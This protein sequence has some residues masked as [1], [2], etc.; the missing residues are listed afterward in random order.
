MAYYPQNPNGQAANANS[1]PVTLSSEQQGLFMNM[2]LRLIN[3]ANSTALDA[4]S[5]RLR[6]F[7]DPLGGAQTLGTVSSVSTVTTVTTVTLCNLGLPSLIVDVASAAIIS[8]A[9]TSAFAPTF[10]CSYEVCIVVTAVSGTTPTYDVNIEESDDGGTN[11]FVVYS[12]PRQTST[13]DRRSPKL[14]LRGNRVRYAQVITGSSPSFTRVI[15]RLQ[16]SDSP[17]SSI[18]QRIDRT[19][20]LVTLNSTTLSLNTQNGTTAQLSINIGAATT[21][22]I[23]Q[24]EGTD[25]NGTTWYSVGTTL[26]AVANSTVQVSVPDI[27][28]Q[29]LRARVQTA[30][31]V[32]TA[33]YVLIKA[34]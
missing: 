19:I 6:V 27:N 33:G 21:A 30:G 3:N 34:F 8:S 10:G 11:W 24:L 29:F 16:S 28:S 7:L 20:D 5:G 26:T 25:D 22:P 9:T 1:S 14:P 4:A 12:F 23:L 2:V 15:N 31:S 32:V 17:N 18:S 13:G